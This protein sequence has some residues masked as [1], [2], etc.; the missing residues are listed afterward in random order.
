M[1]LAKAT[2]SGVVIGEPEKRFTPNNI[3][4][5]NFTIQVTPTGR[6]DTPFTVRVTCWRNLADV[7][8]ESLHKGTEV[9]VDGRLQINQFETAGGISRRVYEIDASAVYLGQLTALNAGPEGQSASAPRAS[10]PAA[11]NENT[12][13][14]QP[15][16]AGVA[17]Q[18]NTF[19]QDDLLTEDD[20]PF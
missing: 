1:S 9:T 7:V 8:A 10:Q 19:L 14:P 5:T 18:G 16:A 2:I 12:Q 4:V 20:I 13:Q 6:N 15:V 17:P 3:A 11:G